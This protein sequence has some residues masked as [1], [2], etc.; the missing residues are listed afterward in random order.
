MQA[1]TV[2]A[3]REAIGAIAQAVTLEASRLN[4]LDAELGDGDL[5]GTLGNVC[6]ALKDKA[7]GLPADLG[8]AFGEMARTIAGVSGSSFS[9]VLM[10]ALLKLSQLYR[11][12]ETL[13]RAEW[14]ICLRHVADAISA[15]GGAKPGDKSMLDGILAM[16]ASLEDSLELADPTHG[17]L[18]ASERAIAHFRPLPSRIGRARLAGERSIGLDDPGMIALHIMLAAAIRRPATL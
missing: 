2:E 3:L 13:G 12:R 10:A 8:A 6:A 7:P 15:R 16:A 11:G 5:G 9:G 1:L 4:A 14:A 18:A 17:L